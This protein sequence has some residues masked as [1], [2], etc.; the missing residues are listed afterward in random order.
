MADEKEYE[1]LEDGNAIIKALTERYPKIF[2]AV[3]PCEVVVMGISNKPAPKNNRTHAKIMKIPSIYKSLLEHKGVTDVAFMVEIFCSEWASW[4]NERRQ[5]VL[6]HEILHV[7][8]PDEQSLVHHDCEDFS[9]LF[10]VLGG[11]GWFTAQSLPNLLDGEPV[12]FDEALFTKLHL[13]K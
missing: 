12:K 13:Q 6:A 5:C 1:V 7:P 11:P 8:G 3:K 10:S 2:W 9:G 4:S